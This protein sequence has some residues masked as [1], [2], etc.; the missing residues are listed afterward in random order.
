MP[1]MVW[2]D[3]KLYDVPADK[4]EQALKDGAKVPSQ[5]QYA[6]HVAGQQPLQAGIEAVGR[7]LTLGLSDYALQSDPM[8]RLR[9]EE[10]P[11]AAFAG[12]V[13]GGLALS[14]V[15]GVASAPVKSLV[16]KALIEGG[17]YGLGSAVSE[18]AL[19]NTELTAEKL[20]AGGGAGALTGGIV[21][22]AFAGLGALARK[23]GGALQGSAVRDSL[24]SAASRV[25][26][27]EL[28]TKAQLRK[29]NTANYWDDIVEFGVREGILHKGTTFE[30]GLEAAQASVARRG[31]DLGQLLARLEEQAPL[32]KYQTALLNHVQGELAPLLKRPT[33]RPAA[34]TALSQVDEIL[35]GGGSWQ[36]LWT[37]QS[38]LWKK[39][40][41]TVA[42]EGANEVRS[43][44]RSA[45]KDAIFQADEKLLKNAPGF[46]KQKNKELAQA[47]RLAAMFEDRL[48]SAEAASPKVGDLVFKGAVG[49]AAGGPAGGAV[50]V[51]AELFGAKLKERGGFTAAAL[52]HD[53][54]ANQALPKIAANFQRIVE[55]KLASGGLGP[56]TLPLQQAASRGALGLLDTHLSL[57]QSKL[58]PEYMATLG[59]EHERPEDLPHIEGRAAALSALEARA[60]AVDKQIDAG[61]K[62]VLKGEGTPAPRIT[63]DQQSVRQQLE[64]ALLDPQAVFEAVPSVLS[65]AAPSTMTSLLAAQMNAAQ[66]LLD[67]MPKSPYE[68]LPPALQRPWKPSPAAVREWGEYLQ[69]VQDPASILQSLAAGRYT[70][71]QRDVLQAVYPQLQLEIQQRLIER[72]GQHNKPLGLKQRRVL[73]AMLG[74]GVLGTDRAQ[75]LA[76]QAAHGTVGS[77]TQP[78]R[79][80]GR[81]RVNTED[82][83]AT[84]AQRLEGR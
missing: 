40:P 23:V 42:P 55:Q 76:I 1:L 61:V 29:H 62:A 18:A 54:G 59:L 35:K 68:G 21:G 73:A 27:A 14:P 74:E 15:V 50:A 66:L 20:L 82:N 16:G 12:E 17:I 31:G 9:R 51:A 26:K 4:V 81:Q 53:L 13:A 37:H 63:V 65:G 2:L 69:A 47:Y 70:Q 79:P 33:L 25:W 80:D 67:K 72:L 48:L 44:V 84:Q 10:N 46:L 39:L 3:G 11:A 8:A 45:I 5:E 60:S 57:A 30:S 19:G 58:G 49:A 32:G 78:G 38:D 64:R 34:E 6:R 83:L 71:P 52:L 43:V 36:D 41:E 56:F 7:G 28:A 75:V 24:K 77:A 22:G